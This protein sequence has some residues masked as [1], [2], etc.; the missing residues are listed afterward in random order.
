MNPIVWLIQAALKPALDQIFQ[1]IKQM[2]LDVTKLIAAV[3][4]LTSVDQSVLALISTIAANQKDLAKQLADALAANDP[5]ATAA[6]QK[7][8]D[9]SADSISAQ[10]DALSKAV[11]DN[12]VTG[13]PAV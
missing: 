8:M 12:T 9:D 1:E 10:A 5:V 6:V 11:T 4:K 7:A 3:A 2:K 13:T